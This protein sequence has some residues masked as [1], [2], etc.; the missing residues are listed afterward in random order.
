[1]SST[2]VSSFHFGWSTFKAS[3][4]EENLFLSS[5]ISIDF[6]EVPRIFT[7]AL[8]RRD[9]RIFGI[10]PPVETITPSGD[11]SETISITRSNESSSK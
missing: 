3:S 7:P 1:M 4:S 6:A 10:C 9:A 8:S 11:S 5:A 2:D